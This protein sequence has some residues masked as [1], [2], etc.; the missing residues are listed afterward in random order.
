MKGYLVYTQL[1]PVIAEQTYERFT[2]SSGANYMDYFLAHFS[3]SSRLSRFSI[4]R[5]VKNIFS[6]QQ[7]TDP[8]TMIQTA[9]K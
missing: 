3:S 8:K 1:L 7:I 5:S 9:T 2:D 6:H 4:F